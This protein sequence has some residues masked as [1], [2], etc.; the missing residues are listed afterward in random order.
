MTP[1]RLRT[2]VPTFFVLFGSAAHAQVQ[3]HATDLGTLGGNT[4]AS[5]LNDAGVVA[6]WSGVPG[7]GGTQVPHPVLYSG[8]TLTN[9][10]LPPWPVMNAGFDAINDSGLAAGTFRRADDTTGGFLYAGGTFTQLSTPIDFSSAVVTGM[11]DAGQVV[12]TL[13][14]APSGGNRPFLLSNGTLTPLERTGGGAWGARGIS[15]AGQVVGN[16]ST[17]VDGRDVSRAVLWDA[18]QTTELPLPAGFVGITAN[19]ISGSGNV[20]G[21]LT[22]LISNGAETIETIEPFVYRDGVV[23]PLGR[24]WENRT[25]ANAVNDRGEVVGLYST[26]FPNAFVYSDGVYTPLNTLSLPGGFQPLSATDINDAGQILVVGR[27]SVF[28]TEQRSFL[29]TPVPEPATGLLA[30]AAAPVLLARRR[31]RPQR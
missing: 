24:L 5:A 31:R 1:L 30:M 13:T 9:V 8:G 17:T 20:T 29:L 23:T 2:V 25:T 10:G 7:A 12:G 19:N 11:N 14:G 18:G 16:Y 28:D 22:S 26:P 15:N 4:G 3:Y 21:Y 27:R 6:G